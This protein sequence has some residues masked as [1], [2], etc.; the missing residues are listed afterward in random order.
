MKV[1]GREEGWPGEVRDREVDRIGLRREWTK[2]DY[3]FADGKESQESEEVLVSLIY[4]P[5]QGESQDAKG[6]GG[7]GS[8]GPMAGFAAGDFHKGPD[9]FG[10]SA[11]A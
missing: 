6:K 1:L 5:W 9:R 2:G 3:A 4:K 8:S 11:G 10:I 7:Q